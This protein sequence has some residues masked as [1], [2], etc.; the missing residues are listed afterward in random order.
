M[1][2]VVLRCAFFLVPLAGAAWAGC[3]DEAE[4]TPTPPS[5][6]AGPDTAAPDVYVPP[7][8]AAPDSGRDCAADVEK[9]GLLKHLDCTG[10]YSDLPSKTVAADAK[11][12]TPG[13]EFWSDGAEKSRF[14]YLPPG[15]KIDI[16]NF[17]EWKFPNG[18]KIWKEFK[19]GGKRIETRLYVKAKDSWRHTNY[20]WNDTETDAVRDD[21]GEKVVIPGRAAPYEIPETFTCNNCHQG[22]AEPVLGVEAVS[23]GLPT[24]KGVT[25]A[26]LAAEGRFS[27]TPPTTT[28]TIPDDGSGKA[29]P[30]LT[31]MH[32][33]CGTCHNDSVGAGAGFTGLFL[34]L[35]PSQL[36]PE[37]GTATAQ[38][39][40]PW[41]TTVG[42][43]S[44]RQDTDAGVNYVRIVKGD[45]SASLVSILSG[46][47]VDAG[48]EPSSAIQMPPIV[49]RLPD[50][51]GHALLDTWITA[52]P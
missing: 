40:D 15:A 23:L 3:T 34:L 48:E 37:A 1:H 33:N 25:L 42:Q 11:P 28:F 36:L 14:L 4:P 51:Q 6:E 2:K 44:T 30:A 12:Y 24:A 35:R 50:T 43:M 19:V 22:R 16:S 21:K 27:S 31:W 5:E 45:P 46:R 47:R 9:D 32:A 10:L 49:T 17:D 8:D 18:T 38:D 20:R 52:I 26:T 13:V 29:A 41:K 7:V 39:L